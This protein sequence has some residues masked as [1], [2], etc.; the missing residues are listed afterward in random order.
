MNTQNAWHMVGYLWGA[1]LVVAFVTHATVTTRWRLPTSS[2]RMRAGW[3]SAPTAG[4]SQVNDGPLPG[5]PP[6]DSRSAI[7]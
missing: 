5:R 2:R 1:T 4:S 7:A 3:R 6:D